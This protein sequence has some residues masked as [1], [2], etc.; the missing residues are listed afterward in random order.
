MDGKSCSRNDVITGG[1]ATKFRR[2]AKFT[3]IYIYD[4]SHDVA[5]PIEIIESFF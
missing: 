1:G 3:Y 5:M 4:S 2:P